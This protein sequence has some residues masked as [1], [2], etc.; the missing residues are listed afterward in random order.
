MRFML[1]RNRVS[2]YRRWRRVFDSHAGAHRAAGL[3]LKG[4]WRDAGRPNDVFFLFEVRDMSRARAF[5]R[6][7][8]AA[9]AG[10]RSGVIEGDYRFIRD[11]GT[12][13]YRGPG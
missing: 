2:D 13:S 11:A 10:A 9:E 7:P 8:E 5:I 4:L 1:C 3:R 6:S 12:A